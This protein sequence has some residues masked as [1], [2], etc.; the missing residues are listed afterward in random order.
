MLQVFIHKPFAVTCFDSF[1]LSVHRITLD[2]YTHHFYGSERCLSRYRAK[3]NYRYHF[4]RKVSGIGKETC[5]QS[6]RKICIG[7]AFT[8]SVFVKLQAA[9]SSDYYLRCYRILDRNAVLFQL[10][11]IE[12]LLCVTLVVDL[13]VDDFFIF[14]FER[15]SFRSA[16]DIFHQRK[17]LDSIKLSY[18]DLV[19]SL[20][21]FL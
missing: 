7:K 21:C 19:D 15:N 2:A 3:L 9:F 20:Y 8:I 13:R 16:K 10:L 6:L 4:I 1:L 14:L 17:S 11:E 5:V 18:A 12:Y